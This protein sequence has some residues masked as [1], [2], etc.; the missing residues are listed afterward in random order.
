MLVCGVCTTTPPTPSQVASVFLA[1]RPRGELFSTVNSTG[2]EIRIPITSGIAG[3]VA[4]SGEAALVPD[5]YADRR[6]NQVRAVSRSGG[7]VRAPNAHFRARSQRS[8]FPLGF[9][10]QL[11]APFLAPMAVHS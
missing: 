4:T 8:A 9:D 3:S 10:T 1:D 5:A 11:G 6:F 7:A 2:G